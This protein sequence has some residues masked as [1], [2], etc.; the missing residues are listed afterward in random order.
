[1][2]NLKK[3]TNGLFYKSQ[4]ETHRCRK[5]TYG[6]QKARQQGINWE[7]GVDTYTP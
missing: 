1:M 2:Q 6:Y 5:H 3:G 4:R 7:I